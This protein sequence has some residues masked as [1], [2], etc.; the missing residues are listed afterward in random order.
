MTAPGGERPPVPVGPGGRARLAP[1]VPPAVVA[2]LAVLS[3]LPALGNGFVNWDDPQ[4][5]LDNPAYR[6]LSPAHLRWMFT[7]TLLGHY[8]P[9]SWLVLGAIHAIGGMEPA[10][11]HAAGLLLH[12]T[13][14]VACHFVILALLRRVAHARGAAAGTSAVEAGR[15]LRW[16]AAAGALFFALHPLRTEVVVWA[17]AL[18]G[19]QGA[20]LAI[21]TVLA[22]LRMVEVLERTGRR[23]PW[24]ALSVLL[25]ATALLSKSWGVMLPAVLL[26][27]D[28]YPLGRLAAG[29]PRRIAAV[30][31][32]KLPFATLAA[33]AVGLAVATH[34]QPGMLH[35]LADHPPLHRAVQAA[36]GLG[37]YLWKTLVPLGLSPLYELPAAVD[38]LAA[39][40]VA[41]AA[42]ITATTV[43]L[44]LARRRVPGVAAAWAAYVAIVVP[45]LG[46]AQVGPQAAA[47]RYTYLACLP[48]AVLFGDAV[49]RLL[50]VRRRAARGLAAA[51]VAV[52]LGALGTLSA[53]QARVWIDSL[54]LWTHAIAVDPHSATAFYNLGAAR[55]DRGDAAGALAAYDEALRLRPQFPGPHNNR[56][57]L[58]AE[59]GDP[60]GAI[61]DYD[62]TIRLAPDFDLAYANRGNARMLLGDLAGAIADFE[63]ALRLAP[64]MAVELYNNLGYARSERGD[65]DGARAALDEAI[66]LDPTRPEP[67]AN[68]GWVHARRPDPEAAITDYVRALAL[69][70]PH[71]RGR[72]VTEQR[73]EAAR[74]QIRRGH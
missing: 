68:R 11:Y 39:R 41:S 44:A 29:G 65:L 17:S 1:L 61:A 32:E 53:L 34:A 30:L 6:G 73:L 21:L 74:A 20:V 18:P 58:R 38:P 13:A 63:Q 47:D 49:R 43:G 50:G 70:P 56:G 19:L 46:G 35:S 37:F 22:Y 59:L 54:T 52:Y 69:A 7:T 31:I 42:G 48:W 66:R 8:Q 72:A 62:E 24:L 12:A 64:D 51:G 33:A 25:F 4:N 5:L 67:Y 3:F 2:A 27:L 36:F 9:L 15:V 28:V 26:V 45:V 16:S 23:G 60:R 40:Y 57:L 14:A 55:Q 10:A 71:W